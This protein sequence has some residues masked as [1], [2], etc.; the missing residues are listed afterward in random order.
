MTQTLPDNHTSI[1]S[2]PHFQKSLGQKRNSKYLVFYC[3]PLWTCPLREKSNWLARGRRPLRTDFSC[4]VIP[5]PSVTGGRDTGQTSFWS[6][7]RWCCPWGVVGDRSRSRR[8]TG[9]GY[10]TGQRPVVPP[11]TRGFRPEGT[12][13]LRRCRPRRRSR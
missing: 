4:R 10:S 11:G 3:L 5:W 1:I 7:S 6:R 2:R 12:F 8:V 13:S 9:R